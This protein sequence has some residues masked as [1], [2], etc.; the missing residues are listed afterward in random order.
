MGKRRIVL[1]SFQAKRG[2]H[3]LCKIHINRSWYN[4]IVPGVLPIA[5]IKWCTP[6]NVVR[7]AFEKLDLPPTDFSCT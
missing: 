7:H 4:T 1:G 6:S 3:L 5:P 2:E